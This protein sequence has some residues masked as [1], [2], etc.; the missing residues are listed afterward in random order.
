MGWLRTS[1]SLLGFPCRY[2]PVS[3]LGTG[4]F[5]IVSKVVERETGHEYA[6]KSIAKVQRGKNVT[7]PRYLLKIQNEV[8]CMYQLGASLDAVCLKVCKPPRIDLLLALDSSM[9]A[10]PPGLSLRLTLPDRL[11]SYFLLFARWVVSPKTLFLVSR[12]PGDLSPSCLAERLCSL[13]VV[14]PVGLLPPPP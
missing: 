10:A 1:H 3:R 11:I 5:G 12:L 14:I 7:T 6:C 13:S 8:E 9:P 2:K 4:S